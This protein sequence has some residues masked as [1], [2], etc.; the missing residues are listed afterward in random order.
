MGFPCI[1]EGTDLTGNV[2]SEPRFA[3]WP[4]ETL[5]KLDNLSWLII[6]HSNAYIYVNSLEKLLNLRQIKLVNW[7]SFP[8]HAP[9]RSYIS[10][11]MFFPFF[12]SYFLLFSHCSFSRHKGWKGKV[13]FEKCISLSAP[14]VCSFSLQ[15]ATPHPLHVH[16]APARTHK[17]PTY[18]LSAQ[19]QWYPWLLESSLRPLDP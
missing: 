14:S 7:G 19:W 8:P 6:M 4:T 1:A 18:L 16:S 2:Q 12:S 13:T 5:E 15:T 17:F 11:K 9:N 10:A 3:S